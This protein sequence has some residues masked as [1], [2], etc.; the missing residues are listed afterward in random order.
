[1]KICAV[2]MAGGVGTRF[3]P[4]S[5]EARPKQLLDVLHRG[6]S[7]LQLTLDR[8]ALFAA[9]ENTL[10]ITSKNHFAPLREQASSIPAE[11]IIAEP[12]GKNTAPCIAL[13]AKIIKERH[14]DDTVMVVLPADHLI[15]NEWTCYSR[16][17]SDSS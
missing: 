9:P 4:Y 6:K 8:T 13:A 15:K 17:S 5:R 14:G 1:M 7:L 11:N 12:F 3:W 10:I 16:Y 2:I